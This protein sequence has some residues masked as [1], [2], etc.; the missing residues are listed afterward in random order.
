M[1][2]LSQGFELLD[3]FIPVEVPKLSEMEFHNMLDYYEDRR[4]LQKFGNREELEYLS[5]RVPRELRKF[6]ASLWA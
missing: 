1:R 2:L 6:V 5:A 4:Y 3:P